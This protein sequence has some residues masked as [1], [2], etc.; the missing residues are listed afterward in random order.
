MV[1]PFA[2][3]RRRK[4]VKPARLAILRFPVFVDDTAGG[5]FPE[6]VRASAHALLGM[7]RD[8]DY[9]DAVHAASAF[10]AAIEMA[11]VRQLVNDMRAA[12]LRWWRD[13]DLLRVAPKAAV[14]EAM[15]QRIRENK[16]KLMAAIDNDNQY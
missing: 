12:G 16:A 3:V 9:C 15:A 11:R 10:D 14:T 2:G 1:L 5:L 13:G 8:Q 7:Q 4:Q 6:G